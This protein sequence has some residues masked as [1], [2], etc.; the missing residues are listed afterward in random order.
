MEFNIVKAPGDGVGPEVVEAAVRVLE[1]TAEIFGHSF[2]FQHID[3]GGSSLDKYGV[4]L[5]EE[6][7]KVALNSDAVLFGSVG[8][9]KW[10][11]LPTEI[12]P[13]KAVLGLRKAL[14]AYVNLRPGILYSSIKD[15]SPL[16]DEIIK[17]G[18]DICVVRELVGGIY[19]GERGTREGKYGTESFDVEVYSEFEVRR[20]AEKAFSIAETRKNK[21]TSVDKANVLQSSRLWRRVVDEVAKEHPKVMVEHMYVDN[22]SMQLVRDPAQFDVIVTSNMFGDIL[23]DE[24]S[25]LTGSIGLLPSASIGDKKIGIYEP[26]HGSAPDIAGMNRANPVGAVLSAAMMLEYSLGLSNEAYAVRRAVEKTIEE[27]WQTPDIKRMGGRV[28]STTELTEA[29]C[30]N[31]EINGTN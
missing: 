7:V 14:D 21:L 19:F 17:D 28:V 6:A 15:A 16:K 2:N 23:S 11:D 18:F 20:I 24:I 29:I 22:A 3:V 30:K 1:K 26:I 9:P 27:G 5:T 25:M 4:P 12:R 8:G 13:E 10:D 31:L